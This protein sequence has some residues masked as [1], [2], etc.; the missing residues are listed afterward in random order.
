MHTFSRKAQL[1]LGLIAICLAVTIP[2]SLYLYV[3][4][5]ASAPRW[6]ILIV[7]NVLLSII[8][9][10]LLILVGLAM[11]WAY[12]RRR[13][14]LARFAVRV[15]AAATREPTTLIEAAGILNSG[16]NLQVSIPLQQSDAVSEGDPFIAIRLQDRGQLGIVSVVKVLE[17]RYLCEVADRMN[18]Q[19]FWSGLEL[20]M[21]SDFSPPAGVGFSR[22]INEIDVDYIRRLILS[23]GG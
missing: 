13:R 15:L 2:L 22:H 1:F 11:S 17:D 19:E 12:R 5:G 6:V 16:G 21:S 4:D 10:A 8:V 3:D 20:R 14:P 18:A 9:S 7:G 23:W